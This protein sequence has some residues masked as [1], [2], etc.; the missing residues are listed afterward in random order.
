M[1]EMLEN[2]PSN[3]IK[4][5]DSLLCYA[6]AGWDGI[7]R[8]Q[9]LDRNFTVMRMGSLQKAESLTGPLMGSGGAPQLTTA[10][11]SMEQRSRGQP[12]PHIHQQQ[13]AT[14]H[15]HHPHVHQQQ[16][17]L[18]RAYCCNENV[19]NT[20]ATMPF[21]Q[22]ELARGSSRPHSAAQSSS[23]PG[24]RGGAAGAMDAALLSPVQGSAADS[25]SRL[26]P[27][28]EDSNLLRAGSNGNTNM[29]LTHHMHSSFR[30][31]LPHSS[32]ATSAAVSSS[33][34]QW[35]AGMNAAC[36]SGN[37]TQAQPT[38]QQQQQQAARPPQ[39]GGG[40]VVMATCA[41][42]N[43]TSGSGSGDLVHLPQYGDL[44]AF[45]VS[46]GMQMDA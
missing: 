37:T 30:Q 19:N 5:Y 9:S 3:Q 42:S 44:G 23:V 15:H 45:L 20:A 24:G 34:P 17:L 6:L 41:L 29:L 26:P 33:S 10:Y 14:G 27:R 21:L 11:G 46:D 36:Y 22:R 12:P 35:P 13:Q 28:P 31:P 8:L 25:S 4:V 39:P 7:A 43:A 1:G 18:Q 32:P 40:D 2:A 16:Q 38:Q